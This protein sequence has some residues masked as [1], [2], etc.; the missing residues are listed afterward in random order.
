MPRS[1]VHGSGEA[2]RG[3]EDY[4]RGGGRMIICMIMEAAPPLFGGELCVYA[5]FRFVPRFYK[6]VMFS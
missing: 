5:I 1:S 2:T 6:Q 4:E 3:D